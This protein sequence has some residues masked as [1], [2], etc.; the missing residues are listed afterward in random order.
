MIINRSIK[1][2]IK[3]DYAYRFLSYLNISSAIWVLYMSFKGMSLIQ[4]GLIEGI[5][6]ITGLISEVPSGAL[7]DLMGRKKSI[8]I[9][10]FL[11]LVSAIMLLYSNTFLMFVIAFIV[12]ALSYNLNSGSEEALVYDSLKLM[13]REDE[14]LKLNGRLSLIIEIAQGLAVF[15]GG[16][17]ANKNFELSYLLAVLI[18][19]FTLGTALLFKEVVP[20]ENKKENVNFKSHFKEI[21]ELLKS[22]K[23]LVNFL[24]FFSSLYAF[25]ATVYF[26]GQQHLSNRGY[27]PFEISLIFLVNGAIS[28]LGAVI[29]SGLYKRYKNKVIIIIPIMLSLSMIA[30]SISSGNILFLSIWMASFLTAIMQPI[31]SNILN[32]IIESKHRATII[33]V[34]SMFY[35]LSMIIL[36]PISGFIGDNTSL[37]FTFII[38]GIL[39]LILSIY[40]YFKIKNNLDL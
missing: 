40:E 9:G 23:K 3:V 22:N 16:Y 21:F 4:I 27:S 34:E 13:G 1:N 19:I 35:S 20:L 26:Y 11:S 36:F 39:S 7:A 15:I 6:H 14:Y 38:L 32:S 17:L 2:N 8:V 25:S 29:S 28:A 10:R 5:F 37:E 33:S 24:L 18:A 30:V 12:S 31:T